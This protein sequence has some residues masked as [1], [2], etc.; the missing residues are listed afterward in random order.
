VRWTV[1]VAVAA[2]G[3]GGE[4]PVP[5]FNRA[6]ALTLGH[7]FQLAGSVNLLFPLLT[8]D[9]LL[10]PEDWPLPCEA[11]KVLTCGSG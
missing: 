10:L 1:A 11:K 7:A 2:A 8:G 4:L 5:C 3:G 6:I 9:R